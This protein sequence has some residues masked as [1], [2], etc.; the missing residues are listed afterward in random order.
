VI[1]NIAII[2]AN[3]A[4]ARAAE[5]LRSAGY[6]GDI[7]LI[8]EEPWRPYERP[9]LS[10]E[11]LWEGGVPSGN[12]YLHDEHWYAANRV[13]LRLGVRAS[14]IDLRAGTVTLASGET[15]QADRILLSTGGAARRLPLPG[16]EATNVHH[17]RTLG[18][19]TGL[20]ADLRPGAQIVIVGMG[21]IGAEVAAS[22]RRMG[23]SVTAVEPFAA[24]MIRA[25]G[26]RFGAWLGDYHRKQGVRALYGRSVKG[27]RLSGGRVCA[28][29]LDDGEELACDAVV[30]GIGIVPAVELAKDAGLMLGNGIMVDAQCRTSNPAVFAAGDVADQPDFFGG[31]VRME[32]YQNAAEQGAAAAAAML[33]QPVEYCRP[34]W[35]W[36][37]QYD[38][39]IQVTGR[40]DAQKQVIMRGRVEDDAF[41]AFFLSGDL[42]TGALTANRSAD[43]GVAKR[44]VERRARVEPARLA[45]PDVPL[46]EILK[47]SA[48]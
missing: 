42:V 17:L 8:G 44:L 35:F 5:S 28:V 16:A 40:I 39:N 25:L 7:H 13:D 12:F 41:C 43:M 45:D 47:Q 4:G 20:A 11:F 36:S 1:N 37:D 3:M 31:R 29:I 38:L 6:D 14:A 22:A 2:G 21:V 26:D 30:V 34:C 23:C 18:D 27:L 24:P 33:G 48:S 46:R 19:A 10:K 32:T 9:P 15:L